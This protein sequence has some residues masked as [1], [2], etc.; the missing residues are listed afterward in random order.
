[1]GFFKA[2]DIIA[3]LILSLVMF[4]RLETLSVRREDNPQ[5]SDATFAE[6][7][8]L[9][10]SG[11][12]R[13]AVACVAKILGSVIWFRIFQNTPMV[14]QLGGLIIFVAWVVVVVLA[15]RTLTEAGARRK[16]LAIGHRRD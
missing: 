1:M 7:R 16:E 14:L 12:N 8:K 4:R 5:V 15:W 2:D 3:A 11:Y 10:V 13:V 9:A 6:W